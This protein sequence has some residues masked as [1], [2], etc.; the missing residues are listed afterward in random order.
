VSSERKAIDGTG[1]SLM[2]LL[3]AVWGLGHVA[4]KFAG[5]GIS[6][7]FQS[8]LRSA[9]AALLVGA[10]LVLVNLKEK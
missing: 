4:A 10:G 2:V 6:L 7:V 8:G 1:V 3:C 5:Q 9:I